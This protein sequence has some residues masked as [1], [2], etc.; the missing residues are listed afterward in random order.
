MQIQGAREA[1]L[2]RLPTLHQLEACRSFVRL[3]RKQSIKIAD[4]LAA[5]QAPEGLRDAYAK[6]AGAYRI[7]GQIDSDVAYAL[8]TDR[9]WTSEIVGPS[10]LLSLATEEERRAKRDTYT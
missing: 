10:S 1:S 5:I 8:Y 4:K 7:S 6:Y 2:D 9:T 3:D